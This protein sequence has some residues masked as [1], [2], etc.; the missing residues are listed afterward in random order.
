MFGNHWSSPKHF[1]VILKHKIKLEYDQLSYLILPL[2]LASTV[3][4]GFEFRGTH[5]HIFLSHDSGSHATPQG[6]EVL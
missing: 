4:L 1:F 6:V 5:D 3:I 2:V